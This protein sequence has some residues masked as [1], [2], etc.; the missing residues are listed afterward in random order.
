MTAEWTSQIHEPTREDK[1]CSCKQKRYNKLNFKFNTKT[2]ISRSNKFRQIKNWVYRV[3]GHTT[4]Q[5]NPKHNEEGQAAVRLC[6]N[7][8]RCNSNI[9]CK[10]HGISRAHRCIVS[11][12]KQC[13]EQGRWTF[14]HVKR[15]QH[16]TQ[17]WRSDDHFT[18][19]QGSTILS[20]WSQ[21]R[22]II[23]QLPRSSTCKT[24]LRIPGTQTTTHSYANRQY[25]GIRSC[26][27]KCDE[28]KLKS[29][30]MKYHW[31]RCRISQEQFR[32]YWKAGKTNLADYVTK[33][34]PS[35]H[36]QTT[37]GTFFTDISKLVE[38]RS[39]QKSYTMTT[40][41]KHP[42]SKGVLNASRQPTT[43]RDYEKAL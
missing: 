42:C 37:R 29:M 8:P 15:H 28:N 12:R 40:L 34:H 41:S 32:H 9:Q 38:L 10:W 25:N 39:R 6:S 13:E 31:L 36:H 19:N 7:A 23:H 2:R 21:S 20:G 11:I 5:P 27:S 4:S 35:I 33:H 16:A 26:Q 14:F 18:N 3:I 24:C 22:S 30:D 43:R 17:Q 1:E